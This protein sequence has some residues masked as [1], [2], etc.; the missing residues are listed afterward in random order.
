MKNIA[1][2]TLLL[3]F[4]L[5]FAEETVKEKNLVVVSAEGSVEVKPEIAM[6]NLGAEIT[7]PTAKE[8]FARNN[9]IMDKVMKT[10]IKLGIE[11]KDIKTIQFTIFPQYDWSREEKPKLIGY[12][13]THIVGIKIRDIDKLGEVLDAVTEAG[14]NIIPQISFTVD[15]LEQYLSIARERA[16][17]KAKK[18]AE[19]IAT[20]AGFK[21]G[22]IVY[23]SEVPPF[24]PPFYE[25]AMEVGGGGALQARALIPEGM[26]EIKV[27]VTLHYEIVH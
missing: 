1:L 3:G 4:S 16:I 15:N 7:E 26:M 9:E 12:T 14:A 19:E 17:K 27:N 23:I 20:A 18:K 10:L 21:L 25:K 24:V 11:K 22:K 8:S 6:A 2:L 13:T 5:I